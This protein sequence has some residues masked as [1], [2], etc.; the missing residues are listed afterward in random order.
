[1]QVNY[2]HR[3]SEKP[4]TPWVIAEEV[5]KIVA[6]HCDCM[7]GLG[8]T[9]SHVGSLLF[10][11]ENGIRIRDSMT[12]TQKKAYSIM[13]NGVKEVQYTPVQDINFVGK[14][15]SAAKV[16][17]LDFRPSPSPTQASF[18]VNSPSPSIR[19]RSMTSCPAHKSATTL[20]PPSTPCMS[21]LPILVQEKTPSHDD[22]MA[23]FGMLASCKY[24]PVVWGT[25]HHQQ[26]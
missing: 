13:P 14:K 2:S 9:C 12:V 18:P 16:S 19:A 1:M 20:T 5:G 7:A 24:K 8:E 4:L 10:A 23:F 22:T 26:K 17:S 3:M 15:R 11:V 6:G 21:K 25:P